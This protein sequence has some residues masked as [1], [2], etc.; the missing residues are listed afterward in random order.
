MPCLRLAGA[1]NVVPMSLGCDLAP[2]VLLGGVPVPV[3]LQVRGL[4]LKA[5]LGSPVPRALGC[6]SLVS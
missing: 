6:G 2:E 4:A 1:C 5:L 3:A